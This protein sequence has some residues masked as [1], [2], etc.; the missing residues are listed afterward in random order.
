MI[1]YSVCEITHISCACVTGNELRLYINPIHSFALCQ[2]V[3][4][5]QSSGVGVFVGTLRGPHQ[6]HQHTE[7]KKQPPTSTLTVIKAKHTNKIPF[8][9]FYYFINSLLWSSL[10]SILDHTHPKD[11][12]P[13]S[14]STLVNYEPTK[15]KDTECKPSKVLPNKACHK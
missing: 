7:H 11:W 4:T 9:C 2:L 13:L 3:G 14:K 12:L 5:L 15:Q 8:Y 1:L 10:F 6:I